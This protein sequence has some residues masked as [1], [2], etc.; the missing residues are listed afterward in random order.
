MPIKNVNLDWDIEDPNQEI[1]AH[2]APPKTIEHNMD[3][4]EPARDIEQQVGP[5]HGEVGESECVET[6]Q[7]QR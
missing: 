6:V 1:P 7:R 3:D 4:I 5:K 2:E